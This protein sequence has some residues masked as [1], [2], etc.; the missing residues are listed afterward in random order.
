MYYTQTTRATEIPV[1][2]TDVFV[3]WWDQVMETN[4]IRVL[5]F[6]A[7]KVIVGPSGEAEIRQRDV[8]PATNAEVLALA[9]K[10]LGK[11][12]E[13]TTT[14]LS[15]S[16]QGRVAFIKKEN[17]AAFEGKGY[18]TKGLGVMAQPGK[19]ATGNYFF[20]AIIKAG[21]DTDAYDGAVELPVKMFNEIVRNIWSLDPDKVFAV[22]TSGKNGEKVVWF[23]NENR[24]MPGI[25]TIYLGNFKGVK[26]EG[27]SIIV[28]MAD[29]TYIFDNTCMEAYGG[30]VSH[31][32]LE[33]CTNGAQFVEELMSDWVKAYRQVVEALNKRCWRAGDTAAAKAILTMD[34][35]QDFDDDGPIIETTDW[36]RNVS[37]ALDALNA[38][39]SPAKSGRLARLLVSLLVVRVKQLHKGIIMRPDM[40]Y[41][42][43]I[44]PMGDLPIGEVILPAEF[45]TVAGVRF[46]VNTAAEV[47]KLHV[48][49][50]TGCFV[51]PESVKQANADFDGDI[52]YF[53]KDGILSLKD[54][55][56][57]P[58]GEKDTTNE[59]DPINLARML[60]WAG[61]YVG[62]VALG[63]EF[64]S[65]CDD[66]LGQ[67][68]H[69]AMRSHLGLL[70]HKL[71]QI[72]NSTFDV[73]EELGLWYRYA[74]ANFTA[75]G[76]VTL[77]HPAR[78]H[79]IEGYGL[80]DWNSLVDFSRNFQ[81]EYKDWNVT[82][83]G[84]VTCIIGKM[85]RLQ[86][87][88]ELDW[89]SFRRRAHSIELPTVDPL[90]V[91]VWLYLDG[92]YRE[93]TRKLADEHS[94]KGF[95][96]FRS[97][98]AKM[99]KDKIVVIDEII[100][101]TKVIEDTVAIQAI[102]K[103]AAKEGRSDWLAMLL[104]TLP[105][106]RFVFGVTDELPE[107]FKLRK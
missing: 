10:L 98:I 5:E 62:T 92:L 56:L 11:G 21:L 35:G 90:A 26:P 52:M 41:R 73:A 67:E 16:K 59:T 9:E 3:S 34:P 29:Y 93:A 13:P 27:G 74:K 82:P 2:K 79:K 65:G 7:D 43:M 28:N 86:C 8:F 103:V 30:R 46:P 6:R 31:Q 22:K 97:I 64:L 84:M 58:T 104:G 77:T 39:I 105:L 106:L 47:V 60:W 72:K 99:R 88:L 33:H 91:K 69:K 49:R 61:R 70:Y 32:L 36:A 17:K 76:K 75:A 89:E 68:Q 42:A 48:T 85:S 38:G 100:P 53:I 95:D 96:E 51:N 54:E 107:G 37:L 101:I 94:T 66:V 14:P 4:N 1:R 80:E 40:V 78:A 23:K 20:K 71:L 25:P 44:L 50:G 24:T 55:A 87:S 45:A 57:L 19:F 12:W 63:L 83:R 102:Y 81:L 18:T 15:Y